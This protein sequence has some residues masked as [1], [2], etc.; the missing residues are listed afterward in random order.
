MNGR[1]NPPLVVTGFMGAG[2]TSTGKVVA[3]RLGRDFVDMDVAIEEAEGMSV[4]RIF[5]K[6]GEAYF[7]TRESE[8]CAT[9]AARENIVVSTGGGVFVNPANR[10]HF[11]DA[12]VV[13]LDADSS[14]IYNRLKRNAN[15]PLL[16]VADPY[17][18]IVE[19]M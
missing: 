13:C 17:Q 19:L 5:E 6:H 10:E 8:M 1:G 18:R 3:K 4:S 11:K 7:R 16:K 14:E 15:R 9:L 2:K 12:L